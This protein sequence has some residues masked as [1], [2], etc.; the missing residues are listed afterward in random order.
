[1]EKAVRTVGEL[2]SEMLS[3]VRESSLAM[4]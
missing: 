2:A 1:M 4:K 3:E